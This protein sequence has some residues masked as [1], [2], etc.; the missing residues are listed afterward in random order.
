[1]IVI[2]IYVLHHH[3]YHYRF[4]IIIIYKFVSLSMFLFIAYGIVIIH[5]LAQVLARHVGFTHQRRLEAERPL[6]G[7]HLRLVPWCPASAEAST[8]TWNHLSG[9]Q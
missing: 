7:L 1:M 9:V 5:V 3:L 4:Y 6:G 2:V 8:V